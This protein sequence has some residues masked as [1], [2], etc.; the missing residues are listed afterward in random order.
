MMRMPCG[1]ILGVVLGLSLLHQPV[2][3]E[4]LGRLFF[5]PEQ[6]AMLDLARR[7][8]PTAAQGADAPSDGVT[9]SGIVTR[10]DGRQTVW[11]NGRP[12][13]AGVA[14]GRSPAS[15]SIPL[16][17]GGGQVRLRVG[18]TLDPTS[19][20]V[21]EGYRRPRL[22]AAPENKPAPP[23]TPGTAQPPKP[24]KPGVNDADDG[25]DEPAA[26]APGR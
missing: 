17:G 10:S 21:E 24:A 11:I 22:P 9:L 25:N 6:R 5:T 8:Q 26:G 18:Q 3:A 1:I 14:T 15:A 23:A 4:D 13:P 16:P 7:T 19:G 20:K 2:L 12:Q